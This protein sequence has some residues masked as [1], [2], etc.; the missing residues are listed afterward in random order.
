[1]QALPFAFLAI[2]FYLGAGLWQGLTLIRRVPSR[3]RLVRGLALVAVACHAVI[4]WLTISHGG[5]LHL[6]LFESASLV[7]WAISLLLILASMLKP[8]IAGGAALFPVAAICV[9][10]VMNLPSANTENPLSAGLIAHI[11]TS[12]AA[13]AFF[14]I[15]AMQ[16]GLLSLQQHAL[17]KRHTRGIVQVL[18]AL[19]SMERALFE[20]IWAGMILLSVSILSGM[21]YLDNLFAQHLAH[22]T[23]LSFG[24]WV[25]FAVLLFGHHVL[26]W[27]GQ[28]AARWTLGGCLVL[29]LAFFG[30]KFALQV[31]FSH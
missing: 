2:I 1:M 12:V 4:V 24:A 19:T 21:I 5:E 6:G 26:G 28:R 31:V 8:V 9:L 14:S 11:L 16:A 22:K 29:A 30:T 18:P 25:I 27:R 17:K 7:S 13:L 15:S 20:L 3:P 10:G 23:V